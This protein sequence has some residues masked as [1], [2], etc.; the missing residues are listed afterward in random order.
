MMIEKKE[1]LKKD[2]I[3]E[4]K[5]NPRLDYDLIFKADDEILDGVKLQFSFHTAQG[6]KDAR[7]NNNNSAT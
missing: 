4:H 6:D 7:N 2:W 5:A 3:A 1:K